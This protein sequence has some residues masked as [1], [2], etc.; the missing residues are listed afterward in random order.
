MKC[1]ECGCAFSEYRC[2][3]C[4]FKI[5]SACEECHAEIA[6]GII[7]FNAD[8]DAS[9]GNRTPNTEEDAQYF[10]GVCDRF[11]PA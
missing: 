1:E 8:P 7:F 10:P 11:R 5:F 2:P 6:H 4:G 3:L 9:G